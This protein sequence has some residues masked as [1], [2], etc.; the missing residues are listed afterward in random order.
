MFKTAT[1]LSLLS[2]INVLIQIK[3]LNT[4][5]LNFIELHDEL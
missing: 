3:I 2:E 1:S 4:I 5:L